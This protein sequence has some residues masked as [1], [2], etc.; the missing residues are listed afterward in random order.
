MSVLVVNGNNY[1]IYFNKIADIKIGT[2][3]VTVDFAISVISCPSGLT[4]TVTT[5]PCSTGG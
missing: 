1:L 3:E 5:Q 4:G 2:R